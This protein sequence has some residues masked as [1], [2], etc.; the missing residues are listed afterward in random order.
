MRALGILLIALGGS[1][2][3]YGQKLNDKDFAGL[4]GSVGSIKCEVARLSSDPRMIEEPRVRSEKEVYDDKGNLWWQAFY[5]SDVVR[6]S[7]FIGPIAEGS[8]LETVQIRKPPTETSL[9]A[10]PSISTVQ[11]KWTY[12]NNAAGNRVEAVARTIEGSVV[13]KVRYSYDARTNLNGVTH[14]DADGRK[15]MSCSYNTAGD[16]TECTRFDGSGSALERELYSYEFDA[17]RNWI[18]RVSSKQGGRG[19]VTPV[20]VTYRSIE[21]FPPAGVFVSGGG[22]IPG[23]VPKVAT[24]V[25]V[26]SG[27]ARKKVSPIYPIAAQA[28]GISGTVTVE[29]T[30]DEEGDVLSARALTGHPLLREAAL[31]AAWDWKFT[32]TIYQGR[33]VKIIGSIQFNFHR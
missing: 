19:K 5:D 30:L 16:L 3:N 26:L 7:H 29:L 13:R 21:Y 32:P 12:T 11:F 24:A 27:Q 9:T 31:N 20:E 8:R 6:E 23:G 22:V 28:A 14:Y 2:S 18:K 15:T 4:R 25:D 10:R 33:A 17:Q 1:I